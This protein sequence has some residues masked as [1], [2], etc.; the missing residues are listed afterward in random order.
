M[1]AFDLLKRTIS[2]DSFIWESG[3]NDSE[4]VLS[5]ESNPYSTTRVAQMILE[6]MT[7][8]NQFFSVSQTHA[9]SS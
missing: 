4:S 5:S 7:H 2:K 9:V 3:T 6:Q 1:Y 8:M